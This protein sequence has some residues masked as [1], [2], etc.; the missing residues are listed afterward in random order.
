[1]VEALPTHHRALDWLNF[2]LADPLWLVA[3]Q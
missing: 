3:V 1:M 2:F